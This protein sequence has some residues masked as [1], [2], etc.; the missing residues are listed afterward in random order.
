MAII[1]R[2]AA[3]TPKPEPFTVSPVAG[4][5]YIDW[6]ESGI[7]TLVIDTDYKEAD[8]GIPA[9]IRSSI[10]IKEGAIKPPPIP[11]IFDALREFKA[12]K[13][14]TL[15]LINKETGASYQVLAY[16]VNTGQAKLKTTTGSRLS[17]RLKQREANLYSYIWR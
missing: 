1:F 7:R 9:S 16:E 15:M 6:P 4:M 11:T 13:I 17:P 8:A 5:K 10:R 14:G 2:Q 3:P 12:G